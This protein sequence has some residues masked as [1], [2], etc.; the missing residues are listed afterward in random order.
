MSLRWRAL[1]CTQAFLL[2]AGWA[3][4]QQPERPALPGAAR[5][6]PVRAVPTAWEYRTLTPEQVSKLTPDQKDAFNAGLNTLGAEGWE[7]A[8]VVPSPVGRQELVFKRPV[9]LAPRGRA[10]AAAEPSPPAGPPGAAPEFR[11]FRLRNARAADMERTLAKLFQGRG[12]TLRIASDERTNSLLASG[13]ATQLDEI[14]AILSKLDTP[15]GA[16]A[17]RKE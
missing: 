17:P 10:V 15:D 7:L 13:S 5:G 2:T 14:E 9:G 3:V 8:V 1:F 6:R 16:K 4:A 11:V 12:T